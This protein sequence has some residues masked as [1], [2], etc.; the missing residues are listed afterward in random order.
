L[1]KWTVP[2]IVLLAAVIIASAV[3]PGLL[4]GS[5]HGE[6]LP[7]TMPDG[8]TPLPDPSHRS[9]RTAIPPQAGQTGTPVPAATWNGPPGFTVSISPAQA[10]AARGETVVYTMKIEAQ[11]GFSDEIHMQIVASVLFFSQ[12]QDLGT[13]KPPYPTTIEYPFKVPDTL[14]PG[15][16]VNGVLT[17]TGGG[18]T[19]EDHIT[20]SVK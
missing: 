20:L 15:T 8:G 11:N 4:A 2:A 5:G 16:T 1:K 3:L 7:I 19:R 9:P 6:T 17:A 18:I 10:A 13:L 14:F 12:T